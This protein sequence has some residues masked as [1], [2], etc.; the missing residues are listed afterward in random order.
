MRVL[1]RHIR[2]PR[3]FEITGGHAFAASRDLTGDIIKRKDLVCVRRG[4]TGAGG[5]AKDIGDTAHYGEN[6]GV[7]KEFIYC[8]KIGALAEIAQRSRHLREVW[9]ELAKEFLRTRGKHRTRCRLSLWRAHE[10][11]RV[12]EAKTCRVEPLRPRSDVSRQYG[13]M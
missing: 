11:R 9:F 3:C 13:G 8:G 4:K 5:D 10:H 2:G 6:H 1:A 12:H 7:T